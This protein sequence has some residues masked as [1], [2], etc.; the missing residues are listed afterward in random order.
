[1]TDKASG[2]WIRVSA[3][4]QMDPRIITAGAQAELVYI[5]ALALSRQMGTDGHISAEHDKHLTRGLARPNLIMPKLV[6]VDL[7]EECADGWRVPSD[8]WEK[9]QT[10]EAEYQAQV[11]G[12]AERQRRYRENLKKQRKTRSTP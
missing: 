6:A 12:N 5:R 2:R 4:Y 9:W 10:T 7:W 1:M 3:N 8:R 11:E